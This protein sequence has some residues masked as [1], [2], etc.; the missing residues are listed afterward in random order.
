MYRN[1]N[2]TNKRWIDPARKAELMERDRIRQ[3]Y[4][5][6]LEKEKQRLLNPSFQEDD[7]E[8]AEDEETAPK[9]VIDE[10]PPEEQDEVVLS[11]VPPATEPQYFTQLAKKGWYNVIGPAG[12]PVNAT[13]LRLEVAEKK[14]ARMN[15]GAHR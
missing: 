2:T 5:A 3:A 1:Q 15:N 4:Y 6:K 10:V 11:E 12:K 8:I 14:A 7:Q 9:E 13:L